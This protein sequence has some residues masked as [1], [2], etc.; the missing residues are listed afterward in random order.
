VALPEAMPQRMLTYRWFA[1]AYRW[2]PDQVDDMDVETADWLM[3]IE[4]SASR[5]QELMTK[6]TPPPDFRPGPGGFGGSR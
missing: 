3:T 2:T 6:R 4:N 1:A 5:A